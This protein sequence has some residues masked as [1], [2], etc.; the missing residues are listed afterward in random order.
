DVGPGA[1]GCLVAVGPVRRKTVV[2]VWIDQ[3]QAAAAAVGPSAPAT[4]FAVAYFVHDDVDGVGDDNAVV[5]ADDLVGFG[6][7]EAVTA[8]SERSS[9]IA[10]RI[11]RIETGVI[12][13]Q[14]GRVVGDHHVAVRGEHGV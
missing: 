14:V 8:V 10:E 12:G 13:E 5:G 2:A 4:A 6:E 3:F 9:I 7:G 11:V 1:L